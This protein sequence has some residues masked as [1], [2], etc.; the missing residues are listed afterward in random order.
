ML[1]GA[2][3]LEVGNNVRIAAHTVIIAAN[4]IYESR[5]TPIRNQGARK[6]GI[7]IHNDVWIGSNVTILDG[8]TIGEGSIIAAGAVV[9]ESVP[10]YSIV[11]GVPAE[12][13]GSR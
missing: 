3:G 5:D 4:H 12:R 10:E 11:G 6:E 13:I 8:V 1:N 2:G 9:T 7:K